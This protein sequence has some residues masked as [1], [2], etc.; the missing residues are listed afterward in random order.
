VLLWAFLFVINREDQKKIAFIR[1]WRHSCRLS[2]Q[3]KLTITKN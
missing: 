3:N 2:D 1:L